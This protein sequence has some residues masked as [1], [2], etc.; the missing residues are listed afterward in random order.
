M[1]P[2]GNACIEVPTARMIIDQLNTLSATSADT[3]ASRVMISGN[4]RKPASTATYC[5]ALTT[6]TGVGGTSSTPYCRL[7][8]LRVIG[9]EPPCK[10][11]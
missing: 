1:G 2:L 5:S 11:F 4:T 3:C 10:W 9:I 8:G 7:A 6:M